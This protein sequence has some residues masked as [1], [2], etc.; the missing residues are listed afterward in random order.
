MKT[1]PA[2]FP[3][4]SSAA[5]EQ[6][7]ERAGNG[8]RKEVIVGGGE[9]EHVARM[10]FTNDISRSLVSHE[11]RSV[12]AGEMRKTRERIIVADAKRMSNNS[13]IDNSLRTIHNAR[14]RTNVASFDEKSID[15]ANVLLNHCEF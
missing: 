3:L 14:G 8:G 12:G 5:L 15:S 10:K 6:R 4:V 13:G 9:G 2:S 1:D 11:Q 7:K